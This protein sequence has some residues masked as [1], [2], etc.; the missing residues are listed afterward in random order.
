MSGRDSRGP[1]QIADIIR[2]R[3]EE[4]PNPS[5]PVASESNYDGR[6]KLKSLGEV[7]EYDALQ[8]EWEDLVRVSL[9]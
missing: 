8:E 1:R 4:I 9:L 5:V 6:L 2:E 7:T 3:R